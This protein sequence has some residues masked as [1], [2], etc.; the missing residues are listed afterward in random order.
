[1][2]NGFVGMLRKQR[3]I[4]SICGR[5][6]RKFITVGGGPQ[7]NECVGTSVY[8]LSVLDLLE[9]LVILLKSAALD[10]R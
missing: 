3:Q 9:S 4:N 5:V 7:T 1:M 10:A 2:L 6:K 8:W